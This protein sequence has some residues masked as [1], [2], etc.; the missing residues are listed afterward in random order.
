MGAKGNFLPLII[1]A[2][3]EEGVRLT[4]EFKEAGQ[5]KFK[6]FNPVEIQ[7]YRLF[8][9]QLPEK[10]LNFCNHFKFAEFILTFTQTDTS[11]NINR[12]MRLC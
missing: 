10:Y 12:I 7:G 9:S 5:N 2:L 11:W 3:L 8:K 4:K 1:C 6:L